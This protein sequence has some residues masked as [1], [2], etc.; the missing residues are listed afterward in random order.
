MKGRAISYIVP[1]DAGGA[2]DLVARAIA[3]GIEKELGTPVQI[4]NK[5]GAGSQVGV[6]ELARS[7]P[8][9]YTVGVANIPTTIT[10]YLDSERKAIYKRDS[11]ITVAGYAVDP[12]V[13]VVKA[14]SPFKSAK[15]LIE[16]ARTNPEKIKIASASGKLSPPHMGILLMEKAAGVK[17][18]TVLFDGGGAS[19]TALVGGHTDAAVG[20]GGNYLSQ[21]KGGQLRALAVMDKEQSPY[22]PDAKTMESQGYN[23]TMMVTMGISVP[24]G[25]PKET[26]DVLT[27][28][29]K[30]AM[31]SA[32]VKSRL[33]SVGV[34][35]R[36]L[37]GADFAARWAEM[38][39]TVQPLMSLAAQ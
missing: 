15:D 8:D 28:A 19:T 18:A 17:F 7:K 34:A 6:T 33:D 36:Y 35:P 14:D 1:F 16:A 21:V 9:G 25:T 32:E 3:P 20:S 31:D 22:F 24:A 23:V 4:V 27:S 11:F 30:K 5:P 12:D 10:T 2:A 37:S 26:V 13:L 29:T 39:T 38:E